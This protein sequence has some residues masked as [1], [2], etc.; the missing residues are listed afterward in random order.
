VGGRGPLR[1]ALGLLLV[2]ALGA[3]VRPALAKSEPPAPPAQATPT[4]APPAPAATAA[5]AAATPTPAPADSPAAS[6]ADTA[7][8][9]RAATQAPADT[10]QRMDEGLEQLA[11]KNYERA[12]TSL[13]AVY[14]SL[15][16]SDLRRD[17]AG[18]NLATA[19]VELG[20]VQ[21]GVEHY[22]E[23]LA[24]RRSPDL[25]NKTLGAIKPLYEKR[26][27]DDGRFVDGVLYGN[28]WSELAPDVAD[29]VEYLQAL[30]DMTRGFADGGRKRLEALAKTRRAYSY[31]AR[32]LLAVDR[33]ARKDDDAA[34]REMR[35]IILAADAPNDIKNQARVALARILYEKKSYDE[36]WK[37]YSRVDMPL[38]LKDVVMLEQAW[39]RVA[40]GDQQRA[41]GLLTGLGAP[42]FQNVF[43]PERDLIRAM[44]LRR[45]CQYRAA[46]VTV[47]Q[48]RASY[49]PL[50]KKIR[51]RADLT[52]DP[53]FRDWATKG[54]RLLADQ[55]R[56][57]GLLA[58]ERTAAGGLGDK[59]LYA[60]GLA[61]TDAAI[62]RGL[63]RAIDQVA[64]EVLRVDEQMSLITY[65]IGA[66]LFKSGGD[67]AGAAS[68]PTMRKDEIPLGSS[69][70]YFKFDGEYW[71]DELGDYTVLMQDRC[72]R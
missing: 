63:R 31:H 20:F 61:R 4:S 28:S 26:L 66:G 27:V 38:P 50:L 1:R 32:Y 56:M 17:L 10:E 47:R 18:F 71:S 54:T 60:S 41:L 55:S 69:R 43:A 58:R 14:A 37:V 45:L 5:T 35:Q 48:F 49:G 39:D 59:A 70:V 6:P 30:T 7:A 52:G 33:L 2:A 12:A 23:I 62:G 19:L 8:S 22:I 68:N 67:T 3:T 46:H 24:G 25:M 21:A 36:A 53:T 9:A 11:A 40:G 44:A 13:Y 57:R 15:P 51:E 29:F 16:D 42:V 64:D 65:E 34:E 72:V